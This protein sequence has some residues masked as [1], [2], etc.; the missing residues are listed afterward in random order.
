MGW[1]CCSDIEGRSSNKKKTK[2]TH[3]HTQDTT[4]CGLIIKRT[5]KR[6][7]IDIFRHVPL[8]LCD[9]ICE[10]TDLHLRLVKRLRNYLYYIKCLIDAMDFV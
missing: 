6:T 4:L 9:L 8:Y 10:E 1:Q 5:L 7:V 3:T 2:K